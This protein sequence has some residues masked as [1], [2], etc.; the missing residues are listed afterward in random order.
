LIIL[1]NKLL[2]IM[3]LNIMELAPMQLKFSKICHGKV[4]FE[5]YAILLKS[6]YT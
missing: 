3:D 2:N 6:N 5:N 4:I 1:Q